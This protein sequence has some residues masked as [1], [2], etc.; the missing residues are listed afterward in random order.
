MI[1]GKINLRFI[2]PTTIFLFVLLNDSLGQPSADLASYIAKYP[3]N[4]VVTE[5]HTMDVSIELKKDKPKINFDNFSSVFVLADNSTLFANSKDYFST[6]FDLKKL[7]AYSLVPDNNKYK[8]IKVTKFVKS[9]DM[10]DGLFYDDNYTYSYSYPAVGKGTHLVEHSIY[11]GTDPYYPIVFYFGGSQPIEK[12]ELS[13]T[14]PRG[15]KIRYELFGQDTSVVSLKISHNSDYTIYNWSA[16]NDKIYDSDAEAPSEDYFT[17]H[18]VV[19]IAGYNAGGKYHRVLGSLDDLY[20]WSYNNVCNL[21]KNNQGVI[22]RLTD[23]IT[24][25]KKT[26]WDKVA[27]IFRWVQKN[28]KYIAIEDGNNGYVPREATVVLQHR[29]GDCKD[30]T[31]LLTAMIKSQG[32]KASFTW[33]GSR[34]LYYKYTQLPSTIVDNHM[35]AV[36]WQNDTTPILLDGT[37]EFH[38]MGVIPAFIQGKECMIEKGKGNYEIYNIPVAAP[39]VNSTIDST[40][41]TING[42]SAA[43]RGKTV[44]TGETQANMMGWFDG[45]D[46]SKYKDIVV[47]RMPKASNKFIVSSATIS[48]ISDVNDPFVVNYDFSLPDYLSKSS[49]NL[50][51]NMNLDKWLQNLVIQKDRWMPVEAQMTS[52]RK[53]V[54]LLKLP[55]NYTI[56]ELPESSSYENP[57]FSFHQDYLKKGNSIILTTDIIIN[58]QIVQGKEMNQFRDMLKAL[59]RAY[60]KSIV[61]TKK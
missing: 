44:Y 19:Q 33:V 26:D 18:L 1:S 50:Y 51:L 4:S 55:A 3:N 2:F 34:D 56:S 10:G 11:S 40:F 46:T 41:I 30:K 38:K 31:S 52:H 21:N 12:A 16:T 39:D 6:Q 28:I 25:G 17:P 22:K 8:K 42:D 27:S 47:R 59:N 37:T 58:F 54:C 60:L 35:I 24:A 36:W 57:K 61:L 5:K 53:F 13:V 43:G 45:M 7:E 29:Y 48:D 20:A 14:V 23:S 49:D 15:V 32:L 9:T